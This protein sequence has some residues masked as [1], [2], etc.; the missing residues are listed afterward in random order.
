MDRESIVSAVIAA[1]GDQ[2]TGKVR[3][4]K[5]IYLLE[6]LG[7]SG[8]FDYSYHHYGPFSLMLSESTELAKDIGLIEEKAGFRLSDGAR[9]SVYCAKNAPDP[10]AFG[11]L[12]EDRVRELLQVLQRQSATI[13]ELAATIDWLQRFEGLEKWREELVRRKARKATEE[14]IAKA[15]EVLEEIDLRPQKAA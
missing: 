8:G 11:E 15:V 13:L 10:S 12:G 4:Q 1:A 14:R 2:L 3:L 5:V 9:Y 7:L 6:Q